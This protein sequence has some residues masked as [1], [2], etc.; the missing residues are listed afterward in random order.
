MMKEAIKS[1]SQWES[2][3]LALAAGEPPHLFFDR[4]AVEPF[5]ITCETCR[6]RLKIRTPDVI[7]EIHACPKC[8]SMVQIIPPAGWNL[9]EAT[10]AT[11]E[12]VAVNESSKSL[13]TTGSFF[14]PANAMEDMAAVA[15]AL[16]TPSALPAAQPIPEVISAAEPMPVV[17][18]SPVM[19]WS[20][21]GAAT[22]LVLGG[23]AW[24][25]WPSGSKRA[26]PTPAVVAKNETPA[27]PAP[28]DEPKPAAPKVEPTTEQPKAVTA[29]SGD[30]KANDTARASNTGEAKPRAALQDAARSAE[31]P[32]AVEAAAAAPK[33]SEPVAPAAAPTEEKPKDVAASAA[34]PAAT[35]PA[36][37]NL[38]APGAPRLADVA[39]APDHSPVLK[40]DPL[41]FD[42]DRLGTRSR[43]SGDSNTV[44]SSVPDKLPA[45]G[46]GGNF[47]AGDPAAPAQPAP[48]PPVE[49]DKGAPPRLAT[50]AIRV[51][52]GPPGDAP[53]KTAP[54]LS[55]SRVRALQVSDMPLVR[56]VETLSGV[57][58]ASVTLDPIALE[59]VGISPQATVSVN[60]QDAPLKD[61]LHEALGQRRL[62]VT[63]QGGQLR[64]VLPKADETHA[65]DYDVADLAGAGDGTAIGQLIEHFVQP[66][67]WKAAGGK[68]TLEVKGSTLHIEQSDAVRRE[69][70][71]FCERLR[72][73][74]GLAVKSKYPAAMLSIESPYHRLSAK[75]D[76]HATFTFLPWTR[77]ADV[78]RGWQEMTG[79]L[80]LVDWGAL[81]EAE[82]APDSPVACSALDRPWQESLDGVLEPLGLG[83][84][85]VNGD[86]IQ[87]TSLTALEKIQRVE[88]YTLPAK[89]R[90][91]SAGGQALI[92]L[93]TKELAA[94]GGK[95]SKPAS[96]PSHMELDE[97]SGRLIVLATPT[98]HR[99][100]SQRL[101][102][103]AK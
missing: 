87:V 96:S 75:L 81:S 38:P 30:A 28:S 103:G 64:V 73:A 8:G 35:E 97:P 95:E 90:S 77:L 24:A 4:R 59:Q 53:A 89:L 61:V 67:T 54:P 36:P 49:Q 47:A 69:T 13:S 2:T 27:A 12:P 91:S 82:L 88:F 5:R 94:V 79:L 84:W 70:M 62:D 72:M 78:A 56:F 63:E 55:A 17:A 45:E 93:L 7:G 44:T 22:V 102:A 19:W 10:P 3:G 99:H 37:K 40:F 52:R 71:I 76:E 51:R 98:A 16:E 23:L 42:P 57:A 80:V 32:V 9:G 60:A 68:G 26:A 101:A 65:F 92:D 66:A 85:A 41:D 74:R 48:G 100:L 15:A 25:L 21:G 39:A 14:I 31:N 86:T 11:T 83:W 20:L 33:P 43:G 58:G 29:E 18:K 6:S 46:T 34:K 50:A 1:S